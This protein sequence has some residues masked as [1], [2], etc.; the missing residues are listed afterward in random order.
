M[1]YDAIVTAAKERQLRYP[2]RRP[3]TFDDL[4][5]GLAEWTTT[6]YDV[7]GFGN[8]DAIARLRSLHVLKGYGDP[9]KLHGL[10]WLGDGYLLAPPDSNSPMIGFRGV[11]SAKPRFVKP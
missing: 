1:E 5:A 10:I 7:R 2:S 6:T 4:F 9:D 3:A 11:R 8:R